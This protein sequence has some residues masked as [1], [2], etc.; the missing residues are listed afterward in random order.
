MDEQHDRQGLQ[1]CP[2]CRTLYKDAND[3]QTIEAVGR[4][5]A[6]Q[7]ELDAKVREFTRCC[8]RDTSPWPGRS[9][10]GFRWRSGHIRDEMA[11]F[12][13][14]HGRWPSS[15]GVRAAGWKLSRY[16]AFPFAS[17]GK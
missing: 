17:C 11:K 6:P 10:F 4:E 2:H 1:V 13:A 7:T 8:M 14:A 15:K 9:P 5:L 3:V 12:H 16:R